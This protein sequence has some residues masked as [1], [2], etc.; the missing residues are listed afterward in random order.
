MLVLL[1]GAMNRTIV[2]VALPRIAERLDGFALIAWV[3]SGDLVAA[4]VTAPVCGRLCDR[5]GL[6]IVPIFA[7]RGLGS[8]MPLAL[9]RAMPER[10]LRG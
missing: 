7:A 8:A 2:A 6:R 10:T 4:T 1:P 5:H 3:V 9:F